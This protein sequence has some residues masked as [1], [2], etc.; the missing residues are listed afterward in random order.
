[1]SSLVYHDLSCHYQHAFA[2][3]YALEHLEACA[4]Y[5]QTI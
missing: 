1:M 2:V 5:A 3:R 4:E